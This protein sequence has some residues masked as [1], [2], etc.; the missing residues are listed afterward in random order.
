[1]PI[2][3]GG[4]GAHRPTQEGVV[5]PMSQATISTLGM[6]R[7]QWLSER[8]RGIGGSDAAKVLGVSRWGGPLSVWMEKTGRIQ[9][10]PAGE[11]A[12]WGT[13][14]EDIV[15]R[16]FEKRSGLR[17]RRANKIFIH[18]EYPWM[19]ANVDR[20]VVGQNKGVECKTVSAFLAGNWVGDELPDDYYIQV[21]HYIAV[22]GWDS[23]FVP[24]LIGGQRFV[25][26]ECERDTSLVPLIVEKEREFWEE[27][28]LKDVPPPIGIHDDP[29]KLFP[30]QAKPDMI[31]PTEES[32]SWAQQL[33]RVK[34]VIKEAEADQLRLENLLKAAIGEKAGIEGLCSWKQSQPTEGVDWQALVAH[35][36]P[37]QE[38]RRKFI[39]QKPGSRR[40]LLKLKEA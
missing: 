6:D 23:C 29:A 1:M 35:L 21:Q 26:K 16:E 30:D 4:G 8:R 12:Y 3:L 7:D 24:A 34:A 19:I 22:K 36:D 37:P 32:A 10:P 17:V 18:P 5:C 25:W 15:A 39:V 31:A 33:A 13:V 2:V 20:V 38:V 27:F 40:F 28:V 14:L 9:L 11:A